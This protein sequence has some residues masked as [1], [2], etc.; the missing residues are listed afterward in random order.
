M[1]TTKYERKNSFA[2]VSS[3]ENDVFTDCRGFLSGYFCISENGEQNYS[4]WIILDRI[5]CS[6]PDCVSTSLKVIIFQFST[7]QI[8]L[9][10]FHSAS[11]HS[12]MNSWRFSSCC[13]SSSLF[14]IAL[15]KT[16]CKSCKPVA[17]IKKKWNEPHRWDE[18]KHYLTSSSISSTPQ[19]KLHLL[20]WW[21]KPLYVTY[22]CVPA[23]CPTPTQMWGSKISRTKQLHQVMKHP[24][25]QEGGGLTRPQFTSWS[26]SNSHRTLC[27]LNLSEDLVCQDWNLTAAW[28]AL[29]ACCYYGDTVIMSRHWNK[30][31]CLSMLSV[32]HLSLSLSHTHT[33]TH[34]L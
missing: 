22:S 4:V 9:L 10:L 30:H 7:D 34:K 28:T 16:L 29:P 20:P 18:I 15:I 14:S 19:T 32:D 24:D 33:D 2:C 3:S 8:T 31:K 25:L 23:C 17:S 5:H 12:T 11:W 26:E 1:F 13:S 27:G 21:K 6:P